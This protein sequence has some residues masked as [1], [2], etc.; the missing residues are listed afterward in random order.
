MHKNFRRTVENFRCENCGTEVVGNGYTNHCPTC[1]FSKHVDNTP[2]D[3]ECECLGLMEAISIETKRDHFVITFRCRRCGA[4]KRNKSSEN[5][6]FDAILN[7]MKG[8]G[9]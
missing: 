3:R 6:N 9:V 2:G 4:T 5:D 1:L 8:G 7:V